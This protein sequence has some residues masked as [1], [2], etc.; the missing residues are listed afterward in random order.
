[1]LVLWTFLVV[2]LGVVKDGRNKV[3][4]GDIT[5]YDVAKGEVKWR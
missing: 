4:Y 3:A 5:A 1:M 2:R